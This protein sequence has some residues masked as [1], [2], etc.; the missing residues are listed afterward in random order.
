MIRSS[1][2]CILGQDRTKCLLSTPFKIVPRFCAFKMNIICR[3]VPRLQEFKRFTRL[4]KKSQYFKVEMAGRICKFYANSFFSLLKRFPGLLIYIQ[5]DLQ[6]I[7]C[8][9][10]R[11]LMSSYFLICYCSRSL[12]IIL[13]FLYSFTLS[14][15][16]R[17]RLTGFMDMLGAK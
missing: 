14:N 6:T 8:N 15:P 13:F 4:A 2:H 1:L 11:Y 17:L 7:K 5:F 12:I 9:I 10:N 16:V 3:M